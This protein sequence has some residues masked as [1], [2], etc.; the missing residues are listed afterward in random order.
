MAYR[1]HPDEDNLVP[2][3]LTYNTLALFLG[4]CLDKNMNAISHY[5][6]IGSNIFQITEEM[7]YKILDLNFLIDHYPELEEETFEETKAEKLIKM[8]YKFIKEYNEN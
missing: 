4:I 7:S 8:A 2:M 1:F 3:P 6:F 5:Y